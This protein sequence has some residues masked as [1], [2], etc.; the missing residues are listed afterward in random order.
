MAES[1]DDL[2][3]EL[4]KIRRSMNARFARAARAGRLT[5]VIHTMEREALADGTGPVLRIKAPRPRR[6]KKA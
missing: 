3:R 4:R 5:E 6:R 2:D 1:E